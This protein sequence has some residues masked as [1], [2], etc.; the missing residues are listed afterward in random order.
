MGEEKWTAGQG[1][2]GKLVFSNLLYVIFPQCGAISLDGLQKGEKSQRLKREL[3]LENF[4]LQGFSLG[5][6]K[7]LNTSPY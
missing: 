5:S 1:H 2:K 3:E 7:K 4:I 6:V